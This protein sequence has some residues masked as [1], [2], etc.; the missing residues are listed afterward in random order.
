MELIELGKTPVSQEN[1]S[2]VDV[3]F[4]P[5]YEELQNEIEKLTSPTVEGEIDWDK[6]IKLGTAILSE[7]SK[8]L[9]VASYLS[10]A[11]VYSR[12]LEGLE[13]GLVI[14]R[15][16]LE[17]FWETLFPPKKRMRGRQNAVEWWKEK[18]L[19]AI[20]SL[21]PASALTEEKFDSLNEN[22]EVIGTFLSEHMD[23]APSLHQLQEGIADMRSKTESEEGK[24]EETSVQP[25]PKLTPPSE[26]VRQPEEGTEVLSEQDSQKML[27]NGLESL[28]RAATFYMQK[29][30]SDAMSY[31]LT[32]IAAWLPVDTLP[33]AENGK[34]RIPPPMP[35]IKNAIKNLYQQGN[36]KGLLESAEARVEQFLFWLDLNRY[37]AEALEQLGYGK[38]HETVVQETSMYARRLPGI[39]KLAFSDGTPFADEDTKEWLR[40][41]AM[42][43][44]GATDDL[45][46]HSRNVPE[47]SEESH[48]AEVYVQADSLVKEKKLSEAIEL[49]Q[50]ELNSGTS[51]RSR[52]LSRMALTKLLINA[53]KIRLALP[54]L[55]EI[56]NDIEKYH[57]DNWDPDLTLKALAEVYRGLKAQ[58]DEDLQNRA[59]EAMDRIAKLSPAAALRLMK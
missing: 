52:F 12:G 45:L 32:R 9:L 28:R 42:D 29:D 30:P 8:H 31:R 2:G 59:V 21:S 18:I 17:N 46:V 33:P 37:V 44:S 11:L 19:S 49:M 6:V 47:D 38:A 20:K 25:E 23:D 13:P 48:I 26:A 40:E 35:E 41:I 43:K 10:I 27:H 50:E 3:R 24:P 16:L 56:L 57:L 36:F 54:H 22:I 1:P 39:E 55:L 4:E 14:Y 34:T 53:K 7:K 15:G 51:Q 58:K 5:E